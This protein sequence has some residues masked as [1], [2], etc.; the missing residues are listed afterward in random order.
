MIR[1]LLGG[2]IAGLSFALASEYVRIQRGAA[3]SCSKCSAPV[4]RDGI[5]RG[6]REPRSYMLSFSDR[7][8]EWTEKQSHLRKMKCFGCNK[9]LDINSVI[10]FDRAWH[11]RCLVC[12]NCQKKLTGN[13]YFMINNKPYDASCFKQVKQ[14]YK[15]T[16]THTIIDY[17]FPD[18]SNRSDDHNPPSESSTCMRNMERH[19]RILNQ[20]P[21]FRTKFLTTTKR[22]ETSET[23]S[24][25]NKKNDRK[26]SSTEN[27]NT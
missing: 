17:R 16:A 1:M 5:Y 27:D 8:S 2:A 22:T 26:D 25:D 10:I 15:G 4:G 11:K 19:I 12:A 3:K 18:P 6:E 21:S 13:R 7:P 20:W 9:P 14:K 23:N 24:R